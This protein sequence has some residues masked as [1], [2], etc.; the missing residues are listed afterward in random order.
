MTYKVEQIVQLIHYDRFIAWTL[1]GFLNKKKAASIQIEAAFTIWKELDYIPIPLMPPIPP[2]IA[3][4][5]L[6]SSGTSATI[7][8]VVSINP[9]IDAAF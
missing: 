1:S 5:P 3:G 8:S 4:A 6:S 7:A 2:G 9:A